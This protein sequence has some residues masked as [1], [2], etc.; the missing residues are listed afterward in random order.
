MASALDDIFFGVVQGH[1][2]QDGPDTSSVSHEMTVTLCVESENEKESARDLWD[3][4][5]RPK[6]SRRGIHGPETIK[7]PFC[8]TRRV[9][10]VTNQARGDSWKVKKNRV[11]ANALG[12]RR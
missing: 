12:C 2:C 4:S 3:S 10:P 5:T 1:D 11:V 8:D 7:N 9:S 6:R